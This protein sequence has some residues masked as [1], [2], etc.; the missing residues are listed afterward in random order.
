MFIVLWFC[1]RITF[2]VV[3]GCG[4]VFG[5]CLFWVGFVWVGLFGFV[6]VCWDVVLVFVCLVLVLLSL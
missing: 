5:L 3:F 1:I 6:V 2:V 4:W